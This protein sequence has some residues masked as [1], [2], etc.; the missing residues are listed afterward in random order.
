MMTTPEPEPPHPPLVEEVAEELAK[1]TVSPTSALRAGYALATSDESVLRL[2][3][4]LVDRMVL[5]LPAAT[6]EALG[7]RVWG[8]WVRWAREQP[9]PEPSWVAEWEDLDAAYREV[10]MRIGE[11]L[12]QVGQIAEVLKESRGDEGERDSHV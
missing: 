10:A 12:F 3:L 7:R 11:D 9:D 1:L 6:R 4:Q 5:P 8:V 2:R